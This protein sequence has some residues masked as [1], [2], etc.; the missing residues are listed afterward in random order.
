[1]PCALRSGGPQVALCI[2]IL[3]PPHLI[4]PL[5]LPLTHASQAPPRP[6]SHG[7]STGPCP[8]SCSGTSISGS[9]SSSVSSSI[10]SSSSISPA[11]PLPSRQPESHSSKVSRPLG[12]TPADYRSPIGSWWD[13]VHALCFLQTYRK[14]SL[15]PVSWTQTTAPH[16]TE[17]ISGLKRTINCT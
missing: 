5:R 4:W 10:S 7:T 14:S 13:P 16:V 6:C 15:L 1:M 12:R 3:H 8:T 17:L 9:V 11:G 2:V